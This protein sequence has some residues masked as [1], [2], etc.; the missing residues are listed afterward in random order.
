MNQ[1]LLSV[2]FGLVADSVK[3]L[4]SLMSGFGTMCHRK[5]LKITVRKSKGQKRFILNGKELEEM[6]EFKYLG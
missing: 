6:K 3:E 5:K 1:L 2:D 4:N